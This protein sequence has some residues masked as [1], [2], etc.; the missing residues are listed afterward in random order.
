MSANRVAKLAEQAQ[1]LLV[2]LAWTQWSVLSPLI[3]A[4]AK[5]ACATIDP[6]ALVIL[7]LLGE[8]Y[9]RRLRDATTAWMSEG[10]RLVSLQRARS[11][12][13]RLPDSSQHVLEA[14]AA[15]A[16]NSGDHRW[17]RYVT[18]EGEAKNA[19]SRAKTTGPIRLDAPPA[20]MLRLRAGF[21]AGT[22]ADVLTMLLGTDHPVTL[23][24]IS[25][26]LSYGTRPL[27]IAIDDMVTAGFVE[28]IDTSPV[29]FRA[30]TQQ[31]NSVLNGGLN[32]VPAT[33]GFPSPW[34]PWADVAVFM[35]FLLDWSKHAV[36]SKWSEYIA[37][38]RVRD[39]VDQRVTPAMVQAMSLRLP[40]DG[41]QW[42]TETFG[43]LLTTVDAYVRQNW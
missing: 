40:G 6:E 35:A 31:W 34:L 26:G 21:G 19:A 30:L 36:T 28:R 22:K 38:S 33:Q 27:R 41:D 8:P 14:F 9:E 17:K 5:P 23:R 18:K 7:S 12:A 20:I 43:A 15:I 16:T 11:L 13:A 32:E 29:T 42:D 2:D 1:R 4:S 39:V 37:A 10:V 25:S 3:S 24:A